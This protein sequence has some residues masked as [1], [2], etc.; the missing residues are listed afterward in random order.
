MA[1][2]VVTV[3]LHGQVT[4][5]RI[6]PAYLYIYY[7]INLCNVC[8]FHEVGYSPLP[9]WEFVLMLALIC[10]YLVY[11]VTKTS[12]HTWIESSYLMSVNIVYPIVD[13]ATVKPNSSYLYKSTSPDLLYAC[14]VCS[15]QRSLSY[16]YY[17]DNI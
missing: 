10:K 7:A 11:T 9:H 16:T 2:S 17:D 6:T 14:W 8:T 4:F 3:T 13:M 1:T 5:V 15:I 12:I